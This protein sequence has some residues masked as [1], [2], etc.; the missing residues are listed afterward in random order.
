MV[1]IISFTPVL[2]YY[3][4]RLFLLNNSRIGYVQVVGAITRDNK[5][6]IYLW[7]G[8]H[9]R[10]DLC[11]A[12]ISINTNPYKYQMDKSRDSITMNLGSLPRDNSTLC[13]E[14]CDEQLTI[15]N[16]L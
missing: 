3:L 8:Y 12:L 10:Q 1:L 9:K 7:L 13:R 15:S 4:H 5:S 14:H 6:N 2:D 11:I 16:S